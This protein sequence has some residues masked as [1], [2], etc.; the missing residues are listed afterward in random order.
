MVIEHVP[1]RKAEVFLEAAGTS[2]ELPEGQ[3][4][5]SYCHDCAARP[6]GQSLELQNRHSFAVF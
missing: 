2:T 1:K 6:S 5:L 3:A 4:L